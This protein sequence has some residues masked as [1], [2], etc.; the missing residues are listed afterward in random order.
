MAVGLWDPKDNQEEGSDG[1]GAF[2]RGLSVLVLTGLASGWLGSEGWARA[3]HPVVLHRLN[4]GGPAFEDALGQRWTRDLGF[5]H[6]GIG[7]R[8]QRLPMTGPDDPLYSSEMRDRPGDPQMDCRVP[9]GEHPAR[10]QVVLH[11]AEID[12]RA[13][14][15]GARVFDVSLEGAVVLDDYDIFSAVGFKTP[16]IH[17]FEVV[18]FDGELTIAFESVAGNAKVSGVEILH[19]E[20][21]QG[22]LGIAPGSLEFPSTFEG[23][24]APLGLLTLTNVGELD[25]EVSEADIEGDDAF[26]LVDLILPLVLSPQQSAPVI[27]SFAPQEAGSF[28]ATVS[29]T[30]HTVQ[31]TLTDEDQGVETVT[32]S[33]VG[34]PTAISERAINSGGRTIELPSGERFESDIPFVQG[35]RGRETGRPGQPPL[36][37]VTA[38]E[39]S[40][41]SRYRVPV[42]SGPGIYVV[43]LHFR[44]RRFHSVGA[45]RFDVI[46]E[47]ETPLLVDFDLFAA[48]GN[49]PHRERFALTLE[50]GV[51]DLELRDTGQGEPT[52]CGIEIGL[53]EKFLPMLELEPAELEFPSVLVGVESAPWTLTLS[54]EGDLALSV[55]SLQATD[56]DF[57]VEADDL[58]WTIAPGDQ[59][60]A[61]VTFWPSSGG[62]RS[63]SLIVTSDDPA[64]D[65]TVALSGQ[66]YQ[67]PPPITLYR[68]NAGGPDYVDPRGHLWSA[69][70]GYHNGSGFDSSTDSP[71][72]GTDMQAL[73]QSAYIDHWHGD[74]QAWSLPVYGAG[75]Y[76]R[77]TLH[78]A[79]YLK[80]GP[81]ERVFGIDLEGQRFQTGYDIIAAAGPLSATSLTFETP[82]DA[83]LDITLVHDVDLSQVNAIEVEFLDDLAALRFEASPVEWGH[84]VLGNEVVQTLRLIN[85]SPR[86]AILDRALLRVVQGSG[87]DFTIDFAGEVLVGGDQDTSVMLS[88]LRIPP[89]G[90]LEIPATFQPSFDAQHTLQLEVSGET[91]TAS[92]VLDGAGGQHPYL[93]VVIVNDPVVV[94]YDGDGQAGVSLYGANSHTHEPGRI[95]AEFEWLEAGVP[96]ANEA[97]IVHAFP[98]G[99]HDISLT[100]RDDNDPPESLTDNASFSVVPIDRVPGARVEL[101]VA[102]GPGGPEALLD[103]LPA[104]ADWILTDDDL[105]IDSISPFETTPIVAQLLAE[106]DV[107]ESDTY[108]FQVSCGAGFRLF[109]DSQAYNGPLTLAPGRHQIEGRFAVGSTADLPL[110]VLWSKAGGPFESVP[111][112]RVTHDRTALRPVINERPDR[113]PLS[114]GYLVGLTGLGFYPSDQ[115]VVHWGQEVLQEPQISVTPESITLLVPPG[116]P[117]TVPVFVVTPGGVS[118][119][120][121]F[122]YTSDAPPPIDF[123]QTF[124]AGQSK[125]TAAAWGPDGRLYVAELASTIIAYRF[126]DDY[127][128]LDRQVIDT[129]KSEP[130]NE[131]LGIA[132]SP[133]DDPDPVRIHVAHG[134]IF[135][136]GGW[137]FEGFSEYTGGISV[138][139]GPSFDV[140]QPLVRGLPVSNHDHSINGMQFDDE[141]NLLVCVGGNTNAGIPS[142]PMGD[143]PESP[144]KPGVRTGSVR[145]AADSGDSG[146]SPIG[147]LGIPA[148]VFPPT[149]TRRLPSSSN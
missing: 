142:C 42:S 69:G 118:N 119:S 7:V 11:F 144:L 70:A 132:F 92:V 143:L 145:I 102:D 134:E 35:G 95:I 3:D 101:Y 17:S 106:V 86:P 31:G 123:D 105:H 9:V 4:A 47:G 27:V 84:I 20:D 25:I 5:F 50:D 49:D 14:S 120:F 77:V 51:L 128:L 96:F 18:V 140:V 16:D 8:Q 100:I 127:N 55:T 147:Q 146:R 19:L 75:G 60:E 52:L 85:D 13:A 115:V 107:A 23:E 48:A 121:E 78:F 111:A 104:E 135:N 126:D 46:A 73:Y 15:P 113:G 74:D 110:E 80:S 87:R 63:G 32:L 10:Y 12:P 6:N 90:V 99:D 139:T 45:R 36:L 76:Y 82:V 98:L 53:A 103:A 137:C 108:D 112:D 65:R 59:R 33:G 109:I 21:L 37:D 56:P 40:G 81:G 141:G 149:Q 24:L 94:D 39:R 57:R 83:T 29:L 1:M 133:Y 131:I 38:S 71:I 116:T 26:T 66:G 91:Q 130:Y 28:E 125:P 136:N 61:R 72:Q 41:A 62:P 30:W 93:H 68:L 138:L 54:N 117:G 88:D 129:I 34:L 2:R 43:T 89:G 114:G 67:P 148:L 44:E 97:D 64:G 58:P 122:E 22:D 79:D 124:V